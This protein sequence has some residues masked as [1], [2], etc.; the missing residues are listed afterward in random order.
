MKTRTA[1]MAAMTNRSGI[2]RNI[3]SDGD[4]RTVTTAHDN[5]RDDYDKNGRTTAATTTTTTHVPN[6]DSGGG[7]GV[8]GD[9]DDG[10]VPVPLHTAG[11]DLGRT[12][13]AV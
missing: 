5:E 6:Y 8:G 7:G 1:F 3:R 12:E 11:P 13:T 9:D 10:D 2:R 4:N